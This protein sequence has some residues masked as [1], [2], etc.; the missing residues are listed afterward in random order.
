M[1]K[2]T[3]VTDAW[4]PQVNGVVTTLNKMEEMASDYGY[5]VNVIHPGLFKTIPTPT[6]NE[7]RTAINPWKMSDMLHNTD[8]ILQRK[9]L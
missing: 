3:I 1:K 7:I 8:Y 9:V 4:N 5:E 2:L 6:Y